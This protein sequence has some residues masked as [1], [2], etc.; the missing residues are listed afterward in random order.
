MGASGM[1]PP[2]IWIM[3][4]PGSGKGTQC[5]KIH[6]KF[7]YRHLSSG[8]LL[9]M[10]I[11]TDTERGN[12]IFQTMLTGNLVPDDIVIN[13]LEE[14]MAKLPDCPG[15]TIDGFPATM[16]QARMFEERIGVAAKIIVFEANEDVM[17][18]RLT[19]RGNFDDKTDTVKKRIATYTEQTRPVVNKYYKSAVVVRA[20]QEMD[21]VFGDV[22]KAIQG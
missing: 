11:L 4:G 7:G 13:L 16:E 8:D 1:T 19:E 20:D 18:F 12:K 15:F 21:A 14:A 22:C 3:G 10:E 5:E 17:R 9:R 6:V 2:V